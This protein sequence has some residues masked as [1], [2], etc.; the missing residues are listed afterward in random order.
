M[1][2]FDSLRTI[3]E[4]MYVLV[5][6]G[7]FLV[8]TVSAYFTME[9]TTL[10]ERRIGAKQKDLAEVLQLRDVYETK[11]HEPE[12][13][14]LGKP[15]NKGLS[16]ALVEDI[17]TKSFVGGTLTS[18]QPSTDK[19]NGSAQTAVEV[20]VTGAAVGEVVAFTKAVE[21]AGLRIEKLNLSLPASNPMVL[22]MQATLEE[23]RTHG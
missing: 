5:F 19:E 7:I 9:D 1:K 3:P 20:K 4:T 21:N 15:D 23:G 8:T 22:D 10:L 11:K 2:T 13:N 14:T 6:F 16:L 17:V 12:R 18:L